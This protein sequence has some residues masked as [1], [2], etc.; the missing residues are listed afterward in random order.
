MTQYYVTIEIQFGNVH[1]ISL[2]FYEN[3]SISFHPL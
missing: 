1:D 2:C 3:E